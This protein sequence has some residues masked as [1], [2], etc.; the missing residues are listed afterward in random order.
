MHMPD[1]YATFVAYLGVGVFA[2]IV[3]MFIGTLI[4]GSRWFK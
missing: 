3:F 1:W 2:L 4:L